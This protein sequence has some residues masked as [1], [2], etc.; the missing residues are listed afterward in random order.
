MTVVA[1]STTLRVGRFFMGESGSSRSWKWMLRIVEPKG[2]RSRNFHVLLGQHKRAVKTSLLTSARSTK[3]WKS[4]VLHL[5]MGHP[6]WGKTHGYSVHSYQPKLWKHGGFQCRHQL[7]PLKGPYKGW[8][9][10]SVTTGFVAQNP[11]T[12]SDVSHI[13]YQRVTASMNQH[14]PWIGAPKFPQQVCGQ[15]VSGRR[16]EGHPVVDD[17]LWVVDLLFKAKNVCILG[18]SCQS[19]PHHL[20]HIY[21]SAERPRTSGGRGP[22]E[23][24]VP[25]NEVDNQNYFGGPSPKLWGLTKFQWPWL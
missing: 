19:S 6:F 7:V 23:S 16:P 12:I 8:G 5:V 1:T 24:P 14:L 13:L 9:A 18:F 22:L 20:R 4:V 3:R 10:C 15:D 17:A 21:E 11:L 25:A 2:S